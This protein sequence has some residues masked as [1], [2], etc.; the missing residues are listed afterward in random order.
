MKILEL[1]TWM[2]STN[3]STACSKCK[4]HTHIATDERSLCPWIVVV[5]TLL[6]IFVWQQPK[7]KL[8]VFA[9]NLTDIPSHWKRELFEPSEPAKSWSQCWT[10]RHLSSFELEANN[11]QRALQTNLRSSFGVN[12]I[13]ARW[14][15]DFHRPNRFTEPELAQ[16]LRISSTPTKSKQK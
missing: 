15:P 8:C 12:P 3:E 6:K 10:E 1:V 2:V 16:S 9:G 4:P 7:Q 13:K 14:E 5:Y 11:S